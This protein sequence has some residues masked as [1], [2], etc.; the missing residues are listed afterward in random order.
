MLFLGGYFCQLFTNHQ[1]SCLGRQGD[2]MEL[3]DGQAVPLETKQS[4]QVRQWRQQLEL[5]SFLPG[6]WR[7][8]TVQLCA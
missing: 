6:A 1:A 2:R 3:Q 7:P 4:E 8:G 5:G